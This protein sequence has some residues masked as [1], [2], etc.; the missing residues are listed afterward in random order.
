MLDATFHVVDL[1]RNPEQ[2]RVRLGLWRL[3]LALGGIDDWRIQMQDGRILAPPAT[4]PW[5]ALIPPDTTTRFC[6]GP[7]RRNWAISFET[8][9]LKYDKR[10]NRVLMKSGADWIALPL[11]APVPFSR[12]ESL[13]GLFETLRAGWKEDTPGG[14]FRARLA[15]ASILALLMD[16]PERTDA[17]LPEEKFRDAIDR[18]NACEVN[19][20]LL[21]RECGCSLN[22]LRVRFERRFNLTPVEYRNRRR[23]R[24]AMDLIGAT[25]LSLT[26]IAGRTGFRHL[27]HLSASFRRLY[28]ITLREALR[29]YRM[30]E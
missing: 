17:P 16:M 14:L 28:G 1:F 10:E 6:M 27:S 21:A 26:D 12:R 20:S 5:L 13:I 19:L 18:D 29:R 22:H 3:T 4:Y 9:S 11:L 7:E 2:G 30:E 15:L 23:L 25:R 8:A 24:T